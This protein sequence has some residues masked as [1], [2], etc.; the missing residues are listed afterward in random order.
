MTKRLTEFACA[1]LVD[2][3]GR[4]LLQQRDNIPG[5]LFPGRIGLFGG[6]R[7]DGESY[8]R[9]IV[10]EVQEELTYYVTPGSFR[11]LTSYDGI[12]NS[13]GATA[14]GEIFLAE[15]VPA[16][17]LIVTEGSLLIVPRAD[18]ATIEH[19]L[20]PSASFALTVFSSGQRRPNRA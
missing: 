15:Q 3:Q 18:L 1:V 10:R 14:R 19:K 20:S 8:L 13:D 16:D 5:I 9:C 7:E 2:T 11:H 17:E 4:F 12:V 6:H